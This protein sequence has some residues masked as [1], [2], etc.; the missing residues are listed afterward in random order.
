MPG[1]AP[2]RKLLVCMPYTYGSGQ[3]TGTPT[4]VQ[5]WQNGCFDIDYTNTGHQPRFYDQWCAFYYQ[6]RLHAIKFNTTI[7][8]VSTTVPA[9]CG[10]LL[11]N[12]ATFPYVTFTDIF[13]DPSCVYYE[14]GVQGSGSERVRFSNY[15]EPRDG[16]S[17]TKEEYDNEGGTAGTDAALPPIRTYIHYWFYSVDRVSTVNCYMTQQLK[18]YASMFI[19]E[20][21]PIS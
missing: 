20:E 14:V 10:Y 1:I 15:W 2:P 3:A 21:P 11:S 17:M 5:T 4:A 6:N 8:N 19:D 7:I 18:V 12:F 9:Y 16:L 13:E